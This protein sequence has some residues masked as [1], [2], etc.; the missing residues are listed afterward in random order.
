MPGDLSFPA[1][2]GFYASYIPQENK[3]IAMTASATWKSLASRYDISPPSRTLP[4]DHTYLML[5]SLENEFMVAGTDPSPKQVT[6][7]PEHGHEGEL[8]TVFSHGGTG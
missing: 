8:P 4:S 1:Y 6:Q 7:V 2:V 5:E 3:L